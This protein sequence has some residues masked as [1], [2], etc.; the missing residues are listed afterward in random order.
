MEIENEMIFEDDR[1]EIEMSFEKKKI[2]FS[3]YFGIERNS[4]SSKH[5]K[6]QFR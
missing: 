4:S 1:N 3:R 6:M 5:E 2:F